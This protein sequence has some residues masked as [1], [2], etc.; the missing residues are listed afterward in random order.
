MDLSGKHALI[1]G[2]IRI[3]MAQDFA[4]RWQASPGSQSVNGQNIESAGGQM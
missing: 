3:A 4:A 2:G 1:T